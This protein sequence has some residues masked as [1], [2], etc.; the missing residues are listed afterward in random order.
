MHA[1]VPC[2]L[3][4]IPPNQFVRTEVSKEEKMVTEERRL[5]SVIGSHQF[6]T[7]FINNPF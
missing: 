6:S 7:L 1:K 5:L 3:W 2:T 4:T